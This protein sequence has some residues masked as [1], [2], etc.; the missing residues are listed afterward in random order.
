MTLEL[1][2]VTY[3]CAK[4]SMRATIVVQVPRRSTAGTS[5]SAGAGKRCA[6]VWLADRSRPAASV[7]TL[8]AEPW[9]QGQGSG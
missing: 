4:A 8:V 3:I 6:H 7:F 9:P 2:Q 1:Q 5:V